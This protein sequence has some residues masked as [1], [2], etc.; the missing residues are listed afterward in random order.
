MIRRGGTYGPPLPEGAPD[1]GAERGIAAFIGCA[2]LVRQ[3]EFAQNVW[4][5]DQVL[6][7][8]SERTRSHHRHAG[9]HARIQD[10]EP[11]DSETHRRAARVH[12]RERRRVLL[13][14]RHQGAAVPGGFHFSVAVRRGDFHG[15]SK[16]LRTGDVDDEP[17]ADVQP[18]PPSPQVHSRTAA[19][20]HLRVLELSRRSESGCVRTGQPLF[21][22]DRGPPR[23]MAVLGGAGMVRSD[24]VPARDRRGPGAVLPGVDAVPAAGGGSHG[25]S[26]CRCSSESIRRVI[27]CR[28]TSACSMTRTRCSSS[29][30]I[31]C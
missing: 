14:S 18:G 22:D 21:D 28:S 13:P 15:R 9:R 10:P 2:S 17:G 30:S 23:R 8:A 4:V 19:G 16:N 31:I 20:K 24:D 6:P 3:F 7:R 26:W 29:D 25:P 12:H 11:A 27:G 1:D 5:N